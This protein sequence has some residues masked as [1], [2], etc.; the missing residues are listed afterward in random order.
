M[1]D[2]ELTYYPKIKDYLKGA[3]LLDKQKHPDFHILKFD[4]H[5]DVM[6]MDFGPYKIGMF[7]LTVN[8]RHILDLSVGDSTYRLEGDNSTVNSPGQ[9]ISVKDIEPKA[10]GIGYMILFEPEFL[11]FLKNSYDIYKI[12]P[13]FNINSSPVY[14]FEEEEADS[15][16]DLI[17]KIYEEFQNLS[18]D[19]IEV[20]RSYLTI[21][22]YEGK[23]LMDSGIITSHSA[24]RHEEV[25]I[26][27]E[28]LIKKTDNK[29]QPLNY[30]ADQLSIS[31][32]Y[33]SECVKKATG[34]TAKQVITEYILLEAKAALKNSNQ[35][36]SSIAFQV[37]FEDQSN[38]IKFF[39]K[40]TGYTPRQFR[41][42]PSF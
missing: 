40:E 34:K 37:G 22:L 42:N 1:V 31:T 13:Y 26:L 19:N 41:S 33:L 9:I 20:I 35:T 39:K 5:M 32:V 38:F 28:Q 36:I 25:T 10:D 18:P 17:E 11:H 2:K 8:K 12:F 16:V 14:F 30:Y 7:M 29:R 4:D 27:F 21:F 3:N 15:S 23:K 24:N 6:P